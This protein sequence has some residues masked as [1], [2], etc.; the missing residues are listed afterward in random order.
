M[1]DMKI[2][3]STVTLDMAGTVSR[4]WHVILPEGMVADG[5]KDPAIWSRVQ[6]NRRTTMRKHDRI[7]AVA[8]DGSF[9]IEAR[10]AEAVVDAVVL[11]KP[12]ILSFPERRTPLFSDENYRLEWRGDGFAVIRRAD[13]L[14]M[15]GLQPSETLAI[16]HLRRQYPVPT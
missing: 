7:Y 12:S 9:A 10:V 5:V 8:Y 16:Q 6:G 13:G 2:D 11:A 1:A 4:H 15:G 14:Q 3:S